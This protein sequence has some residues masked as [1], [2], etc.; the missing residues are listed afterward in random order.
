MA[1]KLLS[2]KPATLNIDLFTTQPLCHNFEN[3]DGLGPLGAYLLTC[4]LVSNPFKWQAIPGLDSG[5][6]L[7]VFGITYWP[8]DL[9]VFGDLNRLMTSLLSIAIPTRAS[10]ASLSE[11]QYRVAD[12]NYIWVVMWLFSGWSPRFPSSRRS[13][14]T[15]DTY[16]DSYLYLINVFIKSHGPH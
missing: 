9:D 3:F 12:S 7:C 8:W 1:F 13:S 15:T 4:F 10:T 2:Y 14:R 16:G 5:S 11:M 6:I